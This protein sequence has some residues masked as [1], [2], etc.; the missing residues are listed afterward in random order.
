MKE[1]EITTFEKLLQGT[2]FKYNG[3][4]YYKI[5]SRLA[6]RLDV[7]GNFT[8]RKVFNASDTVE[9]IKQN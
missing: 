1:P 9:E 8:N 5:N 4:H 3:E 2:K 6:H 7:D